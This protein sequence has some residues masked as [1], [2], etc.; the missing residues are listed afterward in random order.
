MAASSFLG[1]HRE[2]ASC[3][4]LVSVKEERIWQHDLVSFE[5]AWREPGAS[6]SW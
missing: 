5:R 3:R 6:N 1:G 2:R 4:E